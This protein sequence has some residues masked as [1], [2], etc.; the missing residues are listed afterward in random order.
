MDG[1]GCSMII[2]CKLQYDPEWP[3]KNPGQTTPKFKPFKLKTEERSQ[4][5]KTALN[6]V[7][8]ET[9]SSNLFKAHP[10]PDY[11]KMQS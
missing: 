5:K 2:P 6:S 1:V 9:S 11:R 3:P 8:K 4:L 10:V 7:L